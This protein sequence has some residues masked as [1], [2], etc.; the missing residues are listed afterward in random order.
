ML[1]VV[2]VVISYLSVAGQLTTAAADVA[3]VPE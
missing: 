2:M 3:A 1:L